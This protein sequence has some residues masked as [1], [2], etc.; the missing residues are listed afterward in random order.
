MKVG[1][2]I[3]QLEWFDEDKEV[4][5]VQPT[6]NYWGEVRAQTIEEVDEVCVGLDDMVYDSVTDADNN[7]YGHNFFVVIRG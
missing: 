6:H 2:L 1:E 3:K 5:F 4:R 7:S